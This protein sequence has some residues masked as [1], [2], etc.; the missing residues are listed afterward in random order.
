MVGQ[1]AVETPQQIAER[2]E[3]AAAEERASLLL[4]VEDRD[5]KRFIVVKLRSA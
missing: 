3:Q 4:L 5:Q 2:V 1:S